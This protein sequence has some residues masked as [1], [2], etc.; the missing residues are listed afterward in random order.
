MYI[1]LIVNVRSRLSHLYNFR[2]LVSPACAATIVHRNQQN[3]SSETKVKFRQASNHCKRV[4]EADKLI[5]ANKTEGS[6]SLPRNF[7]LETF[8]RLL[9]VFSTKVNL[10]YLLYSTARRFCLLHLIKQNCLLKTFLGTPILMA[11]VSLYLFF[12]L[13][14]I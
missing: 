2:L 10:Q 9:I 14:F 6:I 3:K 8:G 7:A 5:Y 4:L 11:R 13:E 1:S 12:L